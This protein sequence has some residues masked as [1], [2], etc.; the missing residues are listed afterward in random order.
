MHLLLWVAAT[1][2]LALDRYLHAPTHL[3]V[4][5]EPG[6]AIAD[7]MHLMAQGVY[8]PRSTVQRVGTE[9]HG[10]ALPP[11]LAGM[12]GRSPGPSGYLCVGPSCSAPADSVETWGATLSEALGAVRLVTPHSSPSP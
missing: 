4:V 10:R 2:L 11:A 7:R 5:G 9:A 12:I 3:V 8:A 1:W 6:N